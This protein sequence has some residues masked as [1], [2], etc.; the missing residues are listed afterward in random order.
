MTPFCRH[1]SPGVVSVGFSQ[2]G[3]RLVYRTDPDRH[4]V[5]AADDVGRLQF[6]FGARGAGP[7]AFDTP[8]D[9]TAVS[10]TFPGER[11]PIAS[12]YAF[13]LAVAD[14]G[15]RR[16]QL[17]EMDGAYVGAIAASDRRSFGGPCRVDWRDPILEVEGLDGARAAVFLS[18]ALLHDVASGAAA[19]PPRERRVMRELVN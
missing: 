8:L 2:S 17:F 5:T 9:V 19:R 1:L 10:P 18:A 15:N 12:P 13:W 14:Y 6:A 11:L 4:R 16:I 7:G 3:R